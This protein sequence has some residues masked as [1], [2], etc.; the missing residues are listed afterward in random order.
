MNKLL[1]IILLSFS[2]IACS[3]ENKPATPA[4]ATKVEEVKKEEHKKPETK[5]VCVKVLD[6]KTNKEVEKCRTMKVHEK[7]EGTK[8]PEPTKK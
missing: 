5:K 6:N 3:A 8:V 1:G 7:R 4:P 2:A